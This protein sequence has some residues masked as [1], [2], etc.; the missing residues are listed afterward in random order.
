MVPQPGEQIQ[1]HALKGG[2][3]AYLRKPFHDQALIDAI[4]KAIHSDKP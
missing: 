4:E 2:A 3:I 1:E